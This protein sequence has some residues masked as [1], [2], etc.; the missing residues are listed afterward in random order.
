LLILK[1]APQPLLN[2]LIIYSIWYL[3]KPRK[4]LESQT[5]LVI[6]SLSCPILF[7]DQ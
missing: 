4:R 2:N 1:L 7:C 5:K 6:T 3:S